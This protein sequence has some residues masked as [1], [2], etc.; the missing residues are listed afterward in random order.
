MIEHPSVH[1]LLT[2]WQELQ[3][4]GQTLSVEEL[5]ADC[6]EHLEELK[7]RLREI[8]SLQAFL[9]LSQE[10]SD[11]GEPALR[12]AD[13]TT[14]HAGPTEAPGGGLPGHVAGYEVLTELGRGGMGVVYKARQPGLSR[15]VAL[16][17]I[18]AGDHA[19]EQDMDRFL[20]E[21]EAVAR[22]QHP[23]IVPLYDFGRHNGLPYFT[24][25]F[26]AGGSLHD[27]LRAGP[28]SPRDAAHLVEQLARGMHHAHQAG[29]IHRDLKPHNVLLTPPLPPA[30]EKARPTPG[31]AARRLGTPKITDFGLV[32]NVAASDGLTA[33]GAVMGTPS[34]MAPEQ[35]SGLTKSVGP[36]AD[37]YGLGAILY[38]CLTGRPPF[39]APTMLDT[40]R[41]VLNSE[42]V[43]PRRLQPT[44]P[45]DL[46]TICLK[47]LRKEPARRYAT[48]AALAED[49]GRFARGEP[50]RARPVGRLERTVRWVRRNPV[51]AGL[52]AALVL[53]V[54]AVAAGG[55]W[56]RGRI[57]EQN[58]AD[59]AAALVERLLAVG[60]D[61]VPAIVTEIDDYRS[62]ADPLLQDALR[63]AAPNS[64]QQ[65]HASLAL[66]PAD[67][68]QVE[69]LHRQLLDAQPEA[70]PV[71]RD[72]LFSHR[73]CL[74]D[75]LWAVAEQPAPRHEAQRL[76][77]AGALAKYDPDSRRW[78]KLSA[79]I[80]E[81]LVT[82]NPMSLGPWTECFR[83]VRARLLEPLG[84]IFREGEGERRAE[85]LQAA[86]LLAEYAADRPGLLASL[87]LDADE[88][89]F[90]IL[91]PRY[92]ANSADGR[93]V[94][95][96]ELTKPPPPADQ[97]AA[98]VTLA[99]R[100][101]NAVVALARQS[102]PDVA[103]PLLR[104]S[105][106]PTVRS[107]LINRMG[108]MGVD[109]QLLAQRLAAE[110]DVTVRRAL[111]LSLGLFREK[112]FAPQEHARLRQQLQRLYCDSADAGL[113][114]AAEW[115][116][117]RWG[118]GP[119]VEQHLRDLARD[120]DG[121]AQ[122]LQ[123]LRKELVESKKGGT[124]V[125]AQWFVSD[126]GQTMVVI[127]EPGE[128]WI[129]S[130]PTEAGRM[131]TERL[132]KKRISRGFAL[133]A[134]PVTVAQF[135]RFFRTV[136]KADFDYKKPF[137][138]TEDCPI[139]GTNLYLAAEYCNW[140]S[141][142]EGIPREQWCYE[143]NASGQFGNGMRLKPKNLSLSGYRLPTS[144]EMEYA[145]RAGAVTS[146][147][148]GEGEDLMDKYA[149]CTVNAKNRTWP[150]AS[151]KPNDW[152]LFDMHG[153]VFC[154]CQNRQKPYPNVPGNSAV[155]DVEE[156]AL[157]INDRDSFYMRGGGIT[158]V[159]LY[160]RCAQFGTSVS[161]HRSVTL[162]FRLARTVAAEEKV[163]PTPA[164]VDPDRSAAVWALGLGGT[165]GIVVKG[166]GRTVSAARDLPDGPWTLESLDVHDKKLVDDAALKA[167]AGVKGLRH[168]SLENTLV[169]D[170]GLKTLTG[171]QSLRWLFLGKTR[172]TVAGVKELSRLSRLEGLGLEH[173]PVTDAVLKDLA[174]IK[175][176]IWLNLSWTEVTDAGLKELAIRKNF[177]T[178]C[179][180]GNRVTD[181]GLKELAGLKDLEHLEIHY[182]GVTDVGLKE[183]AGLLN[184]RHLKL[185]CTGVSNAGLKEL[186]GLKNL[187]QLYLGE[188]KVTD[189]G[190]VEL[191]GLKSLQKLSLYHTPVTDAGLLHLHALTSLKTLFLTRTS[192]T[193]E[194]VRQLRQAVPQC[195]VVTGNK[196]RWF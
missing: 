69:Y 9:Q 110:H 174:G 67:P 181:A 165:V 149:W 108:A 82:V 58:N 120:K 24:L 158:H 91:F 140:L 176:L 40:L 122:R 5:C 65:L 30:G 193:A 130:P 116:L 171:L 150:V 161:E 21:A 146:R 194:G 62:W 37:V 177:R 167:L 35:A 151:L 12:N 41:Q 83:R 184:L 2:R 11:T 29:I 52:L 179:I 84:A 166:Q 38:E 148:Y 71:L 94:L 18:L 85:S 86:N 68:G 170:A 15:V 162:G 61:Q 90:V 183:L 156:E 124:A 20:A 25:E 27:Q 43:S 78:E 14:D 26:L 42:P 92:A 99:K 72:A 47:C 7:R 79:A 87:L 48:A 109:S 163:L 32:K 155:D 139:H 192:V 89:Q 46:E 128:V 113:H 160:I 100:Q 19:R 129:G 54:L 154:F 189:A 185:H 159:P 175:S 133:S 111:V 138:P 137:A 164:A 74:C 118:Q 88:K 112:D 103:W 77:A 60:T 195:E 70:V 182:M 73:E 123:L 178:L 57:I 28:L 126:Q 121:R 4:Q 56:L 1:D 80:A 191:A 106:N 190:L 142:Q 10:Q 13:V 127:P 136:H 114:A 96:G 169:T 144:A 104:H 51:V 81:D 168:L 152:G 187:E 39:Q 172:V 93:A 8:A 55:L 119:W 22:L 173:T 98:R 117:R 143:P 95:E 125:A 102:R 186:A 64:R 50:I 188:T 3:E 23:N 105:P 34:Y 180:A 145:C 135:K 59:Y 97:E 134:T 107:Y 63:Q 31:P 101:A 33:S 53:V 44:V 132:H 17:M 157:R 147:Y 6:P 16:K 196:D 75:K 76:R 45:K 66:L 49:L 36:A 131:D 153:N 141:Q 115:V